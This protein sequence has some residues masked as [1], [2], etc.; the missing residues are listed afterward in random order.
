M[1]RSDGSI[2]T[3]S[4]PVGTCR[5]A[6]EA[7]A[8]VCV[9]CGTPLRAYAQL[10]S[11]PARLFN[12]GVRVARRGELPRAR[13]LFAA[14]VYWCPADVEARNALA[15]ACLGLRD[16]N[17][18][19]AHWEAVLQRCPADAVARRGLEAL[20][21]LSAPAAPDHRRSKKRHRKRRG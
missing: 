2:A 21:A 3:F 20:R 11:V 13:D 6:N 18:A 12:E 10:V 5:A 1:T 19:R 16:V 17:A 8:D 7:G 4:C 9:R 15:A 14:V